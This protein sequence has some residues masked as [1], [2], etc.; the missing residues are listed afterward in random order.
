MKLMDSIVNITEPE[1][2]LKFH[3]DLNSMRDTITGSFVTNISD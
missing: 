1:I 3:T 2:N